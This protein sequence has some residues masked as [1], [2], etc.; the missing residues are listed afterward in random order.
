MLNI[1]KRN[2]VYHASGTING[3]RI[4]KS[5][6]TTDK[7]VAKTLV[8]EIEI[9][10]AVNKA[11]ANHTFGD[12]LDSY[13]RR[14]PETSDTTWKYLARFGQAWGDVP[15]SKINTE[16]IENW[17][18]TRLGKVSGSTT[19]REM[20]CFMPVLRHASMRG[21]IAEVPSVPRPDDGEPRL[22]YLNDKEFDL[23][24]C[25]QDDSVAWHLAH[26]LVHTGARLGEIV[27]LLWGSVVLNCNDPY[28]QL[29]TRKRKHGRKFTR[30]VPLNGAVVDTF[31]S[32]ATKYPTAPDDKVFPMWADQRSAGR[33]VKKLAALVGIED[34]R[35]HDLRRTFATR[36]LNVSVNPRTVAD[37]LGHTDLTMV[38]RYMVPPDEL[39]RS[40]V[41]SLSKINSDSIGV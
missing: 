32:M 22:R 24:F 35:P 20:N 39:K 1:V 30:Q 6:N 3:V 9:D 33:E 36:L 7:K 41:E 16:F 27:N 29:T 18:D 31:R 37:L 40:A 8:Q 38:M 34:F 25:T 15:L 19:R 12:A 21:W 14:N 11:G 17:L 5:L 26:I 13:L 10:T 23:L 28:V 4:R 2:G